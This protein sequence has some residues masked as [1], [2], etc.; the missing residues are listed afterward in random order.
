MKKTKVVNLYREEYDIYI[1]RAGK[2][3]SGKWGNPFSQGTR[4]ENI[5][6]FR[7]WIHTQP[8]LLNDILELKG[9]RLGCF[10]AP[11]PCH[12]DVLAELA[13]NTERNFGP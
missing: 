2:G 10:C 9:K 13:D 8:H 11:K 7:E 3:Q 12:G 1:G 4:E 5:A 6:A